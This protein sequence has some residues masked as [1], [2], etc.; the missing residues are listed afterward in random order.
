MAGA[1]GWRVAE[2]EQVKLD[3][4]PVAVV[5]VVGAERA[6]LV[7]RLTPVVP[8]EGGY[9]EQGHEEEQECGHG[10]NY[11]SGKLVPPVAFLTMFD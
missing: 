5:A 10:S 1:A 7:R 9:H 3:P 6:G 4:G 8:L 11:V 2:G